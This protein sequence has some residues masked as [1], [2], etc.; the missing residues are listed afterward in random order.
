[1]SVRWLTLGITAVCGA[2]GPGAYG[3]DPSP[4][5]PWS[6]RV[7]VQMVSV[8]MEDA[9]NLVPAL[10]NDQTAQVAS[11][12]L[13][14]MLALDRAVLLGWPMTWTRGT[15]S[16]SG[17]P[18]RAVGE[19][20]REIRYTSSYEPFRETFS[21]LPWLFKARW[22]FASPSTFDTRDTGSVLEVEAAAV[23]AG[24]RIIALNLVPQVVRFLGFDEH[25]TQRSPLGIEGIMTQPKFWTSKSTMQL[26]VANDRP[27]LVGSFVVPK[28]EPHVELF[29]LRAQAT[30]LPPEANLPD[31]KPPEP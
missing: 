30:T 6:V 11:D 10:T 1:M 20:V 23:E 15:S 22:G 3:A 17:E 14:E 16:A 18:R 29:I 31:P 4:A 8:S 25:R 12:R 7:E 5:L 13:Q 26:R 2:I 21:P 9:R 24:G 19:S 28:P 27:T